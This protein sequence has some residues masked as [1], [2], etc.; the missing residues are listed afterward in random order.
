MFVGF[1]V[2]DVLFAVYSGSQRRRLMPSV[3][4]SICSACLLAGRHDF[5][6]NCGGSFVQQIEHWRFSWPCNPLSVFGL[7]KALAILK[8][9]LFTSSCLASKENTNGAFFA[10]HSLKAS[11][12]CFHPVQFR[13]GPYKNRRS[14]QKQMIELLCPSGPAFLSPLPLG[15]S[16]GFFNSPTP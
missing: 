3:S 10:S 11:F 8:R 15:F 12:R 13:H 16:L 4:C 9:W 5:K 7:F 2:A 14:S 1:A 6:E